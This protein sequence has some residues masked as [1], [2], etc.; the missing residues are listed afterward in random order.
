MHCVR[1]IHSAFLV[2]F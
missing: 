1:K 2:H